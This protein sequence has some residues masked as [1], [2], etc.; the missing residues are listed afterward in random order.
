MT[1]GW[2]EAYS[3]VARVQM[4]LAKY[5]S[6]DKGAERLLAQDYH[7][8]MVKACEGA[9]TRTLKFRGGMPVLGSIKL[10]T[11]CVEPAFAA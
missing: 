10:S 7:P 3:L 9:G 2:D 6:G 4:H 11:W 8:A 5:Y 1:V